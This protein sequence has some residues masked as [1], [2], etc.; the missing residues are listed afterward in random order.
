MSGKQP[1]KNNNRSG[2][3]VTFSIFKTSV[4]GQCSWFHW[5]F[6]CTRQHFSCK[7][8]TTQNTKLH[9]QDLNITKVK[10]IYTTANVLV[11]YFIDFF[12]LHDLVDKLTRQ[13]LYTSG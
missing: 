7:I 1:K 9:T 4:S 5:I 3:T 10:T 8:L 6:N 12:L 11:M 13:Y 2:K